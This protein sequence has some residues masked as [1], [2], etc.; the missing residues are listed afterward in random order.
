MKR[1]TAIEK[2]TRSGENLTKDDLVFLYEL[3]APSKVSATSAIRGSRKSVMQGIPRKT[4]RSSSN[5][6]KDQIAHYPSEINEDTKAYVGPSRAQKQSK[7]GKEEF[8]PEYKDIFKNERH[9]HIYASF[10]EGRIRKESVEIGG[11]DAK[12]LIR[13]MREKNINI[14][15]YAED[16]MKSKDF[17]TQKK[18]ESEILIRPK[19][20]DL[21]FPKA[22]I[23]QRTRS[24]GASRN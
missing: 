11:K 6:T 5:A 13:E 18:S 15:S 20:G 21:G 23:R 17:T 19:V 2:K 3:D 7:T 16:M 4:C 8:L 9:R 1:L 10:P 22:N 12:E 14:S 24:I